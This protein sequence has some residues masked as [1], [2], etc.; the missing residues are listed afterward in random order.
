MLPTNVLD[1]A[2]YNPATTNAVFV[3]DGDGK[4]V[5][6]IIGGVTTL[7]V[8]STYEISGGAGMPRTLSKYYF[9][10]AQRVAVRKAGVLTYLLS[11]QLGSTSMTVDASGTML[12]ETRYKAWGEERYNS[13]TQA[14]KY[15][16][17]GQYS[18][19]SDFGLMYYN[20]RWYDP[21]NTH[22]TSPD[23]IIPD[24]YNTLDWDRYAYSRSNPLKYSD[25]SGHFVNL[26][27]G[28]VLGAAVGIAVVGA[29]AYFH[30]EVQLSARDIVIAAG[31]GAAAGTLISTGVGAG[32]GTALG[33]TL[34]GAGV[35]GGA[36]AVA[37][38]ATSGSEYNSDE[39]AIN[40]SIGAVAGAGS[41]YIG[42]VAA[43]TQFA[44]QVGAKGAQLGLSVLAGE[45]QQITGDAFGGNLSNSSD[46]AAS[47]LAG[48]LA[49]G[50]SVIVDAIY[51]GG[52]SVVGPVS[53]SVL[54]EYGNNTFTKQV[55]TLNNK[56]PSRKYNNACWANQQ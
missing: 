28:A 48:A 17:T 30:P 37:Y 24:N 44:A 20:A 8:S 56:Y 29:N 5:K 22:F 1:L 35:G 11:D 34:L 18:N 13:G 2:S 23:T 38:T 3:Y 54:I 53:R 26:M 10:G 52:G 55:T 32:A 45:A 19:V 31:V 21:Y 49:Y 6:S 9:A 25:P 12:A 7:F 51:P 4:R 50:A 46:L 36:T 47:G 14:T 42:A 27:V 15:T 43:G 33:A 40:A 16:Y 39:M 41:G